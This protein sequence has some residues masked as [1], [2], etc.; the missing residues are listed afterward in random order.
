VRAVGAG[1]LRASAGG[2]RE[3]RIGDLVRMRD[4]LRTLVGTCARPRQE[5]RDCP[6]LEAMYTDGHGPAD[7]ALAAPGGP[8]SAR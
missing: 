7:G 6:L 8:G 1:V 5:Q 4:S 3:A 2:R